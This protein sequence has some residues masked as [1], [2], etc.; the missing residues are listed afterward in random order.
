MVEKTAI[1]KSLWPIERRPIPKGLKQDDLGFSYTPNGS[2][3]DADGEYF[4]KNGF[5]VHGGWYTKEKEYI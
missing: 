2:F 3:F 5:D 4:N 1:N